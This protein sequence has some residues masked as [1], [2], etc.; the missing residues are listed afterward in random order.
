MSYSKLGLSLQLL[1][2]SDD[3][4]PF[5]VLPEKIIPGWFLDFHWAALLSSIDFLVCCA[6]LPGSTTQFLIGEWNSPEWSWSWLQ[7]S[8]APSVPVLCKHCWVKFALQSWSRM[9]HAKDYLGI[10]VGVLI[11]SKNCYVR[12]TAAEWSELEGAVMPDLGWPSVPL[13]AQHSSWLLLVNGVWNQFVFRV[14]DGS[15]WLISALLCF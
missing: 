14:E 7:F 12:G 5:F 1:A 15:D 3:S 11:S 10:K 13:R 2:V 9:I 8:P 4:V 6:V